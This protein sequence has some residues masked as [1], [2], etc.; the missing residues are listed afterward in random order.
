VRPEE[1]NSLTTLIAI[2][3]IHNLPSRREVSHGGLDD[4]KCL[5]SGKQN[6]KVGSP[7]WWTVIV[8]SVTFERRKG[9]ILKRSRT[10]TRIHI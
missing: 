9:I 1:L 2:T 5:L 8:I 6:F 10:I 3:Q 7:L 4:I